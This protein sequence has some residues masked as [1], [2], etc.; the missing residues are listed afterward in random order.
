M[1]KELQAA[2]LRQL[3]EYDQNTG[4]FTSLVGRGP[5]RVGQRV[6][7]VNRAGYLQIQI[8]GTIYYGHRLAWLY[9]HGEWPAEMIDHING[10]RSDNRISNLRDVSSQ[11]NVQNVK[12][13]RR[14][15]KSG[16]LG[17]SL[18]SDGRWQ[19]RIKMRGQ[20]KSLGLFA[21]PEAAS[22]VY[23]AAKRAEHKG[24]TI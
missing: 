13:A 20:Y 4:H 23:L 10:S 7:C 8:A 14:D 12:S 11:L 24:C 6:G 15:N 22:E 21:S 19:A 17:V 5:I 3:L 16:F 2:D 1:S 18:H 9:V